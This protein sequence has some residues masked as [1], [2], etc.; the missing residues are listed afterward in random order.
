MRLDNIVCHDES[1]TITSLP[2]TMELAVITKEILLQNLGNTPNKWPYEDRILVLL[3]PS[4]YADVENYHA[5]SGMSMVQILAPHQVDHLDRTFLIKLMEK[6]EK[7]QPG[8]EQY[9][10]RN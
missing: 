9:I 7:I 2:L 8:I 6:L 1:F 4:F 10:S 5:N 3:E